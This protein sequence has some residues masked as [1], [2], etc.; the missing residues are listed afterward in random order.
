MTHPTDLELVEFVDGLLTEPDAGV[1]RLHL[2][3]CDL[4]RALVTDIGPANWSEQ[5]PTAAAPL[6]SGGLKDGF[7]STHGDPKPG[8]L[9]HLEWEEDATLALVLAV[10]PNRVHIV[11]VVVDTDAA[12]EAIVRIS[13]DD[14]PLGVDLAA[15][16][17]L[18]AS[19]SVGVLYVSFGSV[20]AAAVAQVHRLASGGRTLAS[21]CDGVTA[22]YAR[23]ATVV[24]R[25]SAAQWAG[26]STQDPVDLRKRA[27]DLGISVAKLS[28]DLAVAP[29]EI[30]ELF[31]GQ[32]APSAKEAEALSNILQI[33]LV[34]ISRTP[35]IPEDIVRSIERPAWRPRLRDRA[36]QRGISEAA[37]RQQLAVDLLPVAARTT[38]T[39][40]GRPD[41][42]QLIAEV[43]ADDG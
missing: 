15:W 42:N 16:V 17:S 35:T 10:D 2:D 5:A 43:L 3:V 40:R 30:T 24:G 18:V 19:V 7:A 11:P 31:R 33:D 32:R 22:G 39:A 20:S 14:G 36:R 37:A 6:T 13:A 8:E 1:V 12:N 26:A 23:V 41:W 25:L 21:S 29:G 27:Q 28:Q 4:C 34:D 9:W 38:G